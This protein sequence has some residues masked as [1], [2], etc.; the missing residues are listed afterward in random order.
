MIDLFEKCHEINSL[1]RVN[2]EQARNE[3]ILLLDIMSKERIG[4]N[5][6]E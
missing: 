2:E 5:P 6:S 4:V 1:I 3:V